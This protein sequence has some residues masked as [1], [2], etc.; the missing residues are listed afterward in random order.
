MTRLGVNIDHV[1]TLR[2][3]RKI[4]EPDPVHALVIAES[5]GADG[6]TVHLR[7]DRRHMQERDIRIMAQMCKTRLNIEMAATQEMFRI[8]CEIK[9]YSVTFVPERR[10]EVTTEGGLDVLLHSKTLKPMIQDYHDQ[11]IRISIFVDPSNEQIKAC[12]RLGVEIIEL[13]T[14]R[15]ADATD[16]EQY[17]LELDKLRNAARYAHKTGL[18]VAAGHGLNLRN[19]GSIAAIP[20]IEELNIGHSIIGRA[21]FVGLEKAISEMK[22][23]MK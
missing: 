19:V 16:D 11:D 8:A 7:G 22:E 6:I 13:N 4:S 15:F 2:E 21:I 23:K 10:E 18:R 17:G 12:A 1:A 3:A 9:P 5:A 20:E 14:G